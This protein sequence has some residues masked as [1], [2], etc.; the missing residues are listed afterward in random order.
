MDGFPATNGC[1]TP[2]LF[3]DHCTRYQ[4]A[5]RD[6]VRLGW[7]AFGGNPVFAQQIGYKFQYYHNGVT[8]TQQCLAG[9]RLH[10]QALHRSHKNRS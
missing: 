9:R 1:S 6:G 3:H 2:Q 8:F 5:K 7:F 4:H 10:E